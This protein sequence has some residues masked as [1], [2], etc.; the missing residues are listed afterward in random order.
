MVEKRKLKPKSCPDY[1]CG[2]P[3][4]FH[5]IVASPEA[6]AEFEELNKFKLTKDEPFD[7]EKLRAR[8]RRK[9]GEERGYF[10]PSGVKKRAKKQ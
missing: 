2:E 10:R 7:Y 1:V 5:P 3:A 9:E 8:K 4:V 6:E